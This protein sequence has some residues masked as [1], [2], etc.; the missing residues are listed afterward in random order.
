MFGS[1]V[2]DIFETWKV[3]A[4]HKINAFINPGTDIWWRAAGK[5]SDTAGLQ[6]MC[7][8]S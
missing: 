1:P 3:S 2:V 6:G 7:R 5:A 8:K 4:N